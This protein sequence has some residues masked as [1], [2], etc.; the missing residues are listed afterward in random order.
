M[1]SSQ[2]DRWNLD[3]IYTQFHLSK[4]R[5]IRLRTHLNSHLSAVYLLGVVEF[6]KK[7]GLMILGCQRKICSIDSA[8][9]SC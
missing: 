3:I 5:E 6:Q 4:T 7:T 9:Q 1:R 2:T 8:K